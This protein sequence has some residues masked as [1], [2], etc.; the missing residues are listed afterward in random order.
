LAY[1]LLHFSGEVIPTL[2]NLRIRGLHVAIG[3]LRKD[4]RFSSHGSAL[5]DPFGRRDPIPI[6]GMEV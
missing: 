3:A 2:C 6:V 1:H 5:P 4:A